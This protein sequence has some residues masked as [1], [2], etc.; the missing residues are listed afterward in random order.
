MVA[1][2]IVVITV[3]AVVESLDVALAVVTVVLDCAVFIPP[4]PRLARAVATVIT[5]D[6]DR[7]AGDGDE[8]AGYHAEYGT[9]G[10]PQICVPHYKASRSKVDNN[11]KASDF[12]PRPSRTWNLH[13][14]QDRD[15]DHHHL[16][17]HH[18]HHHHYS[19]SI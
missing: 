6:E 7:H 12:K 1:L 9:V 17:H 19:L 15:N 14:G 2:G 13:D 4:S 10:Q 16:H 18:H 11:C 3:V 8:L 5:S